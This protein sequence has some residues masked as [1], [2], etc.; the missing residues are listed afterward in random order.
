MDRFSAKLTTVMNYKD[1]G[2]YGDNSYRGNCSGHVQKSLFEYYQPKKVLDPFVGGGTTIDVCEELGI[3]NL[4]LDLNPRYGSFDILADEI[5]ESSD[6]CFSHPA[7]HNIIEYSGNMWDRNKPH[8]NDLSRCSSYEDFIKKLDIAHAKMYNSLRKGGHLAILVGDV[9][10]R[11]VFYSIIKNMSWYG[12]PQQH[13]IKLQ[14]N[15][16]SDSIQYGNSKFIPIVHEHLIILRKD[17]EYIIKASITKTITLDSRTRAKLSWFNVVMNAMEKLGGKASLKELYKEIEGHAK[18]K[19]NQYW[20]E[21]IRQ[22]VQ[23]YKDFQNIGL[24]EYKLVPL[25]QTVGVA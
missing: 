12:T 24:G 8:P 25:G 22:V 11:G 5:P 7:Y 16:F 18:T 1:R 14:H 20:K 23:T 2:K 4:C 19:T 10:K 15:C 17:D 6:F 9:K 3:D 13:I 21:K